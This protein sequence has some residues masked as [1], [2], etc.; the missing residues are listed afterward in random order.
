[1]VSNYL[2][3]LNLDF[4]TRIMRIFIDESGHT[5]DLIKHG[6]MSFGGQPHFVLC[7]IGPASDDLMVEI[8]AGVARSHQLKMAEI[9]SDKLKNRPWVSRDVAFALREANIPIYV[10]A[11]DKRFYLITQIVNCQVMSGVTFGSEEDMFI[12]NVFGDFLYEFLPDYCLLAF[13]EAC[14]TDSVG[15][16]QAS[17][18][19][20]HSWAAT[21]ES[22]AFQENE[23]A[24]G[25]E[26]S[27]AESADDFR[28]AIC[29]N[30]L[31]Y[32]RFLPIP[33]K[34]KKNS[35]YWVLPNYSSLTNLYARI[36][37]RHDRHVKGITLVHDEQSQYD[38]ILR[39]AMCAVESLK[40]LGGGPFFPEVNYS[41][42]ESA[43]LEFARSADTPGLM[44]ADIIGGHVRRLLLN[45]A[46][47]NDI[48][49]DSWA[50]FDSIWNAPE[51]E[52]GSSIN[53]VLPTAAVRDLQYSLLREK[54][55]I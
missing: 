29:E 28:I 26:S 54:A 6:N 17:I 4:G 9:K 39:D 42:T 12:Q 32:R 18:E 38:E 23:I 47:G 51:T 37:H 36:N 15:S 10:E 22:D 40:D 45:R 49:A 27:L 3:R 43:V 30:P 33:D 2:N 21:F 34:G 24:R 46:Q 41:F 8:L 11:V 52:T 19:H 48:H 13:I 53:F 7:A 44:V 50:A 31:N 25:L 14:K 16:T 35:I 1:M 5:G 20:L 55:L